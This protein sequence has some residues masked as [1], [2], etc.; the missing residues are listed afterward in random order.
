MSLTWIVP[1]LLCP[2]ARLWSSWLNRLGLDRLNEAA[3][4][5]DVDRAEREFETLIPQVPLEKSTVVY[6]TLLKAALL[7]RN[8]G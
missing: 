3:V 7:S 6:N 4:D 1:P 2:R 5:G 8:D